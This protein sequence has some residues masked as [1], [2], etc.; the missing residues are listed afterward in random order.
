MRTEVYER[1]LP[2]HPEMAEYLE[3]AAEAVVDPDV[4]LE[5]DD[6]SLVSYRMGLGRDKFEKCFVVVPVHYSKT[7]WGE[8]G[9]VATFHLARRLGRGKLTWTRPR[10]QS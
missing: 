2:K 10:T 9:E 3:E 8:I 4:V 6:G 5:E 7:F 1:H